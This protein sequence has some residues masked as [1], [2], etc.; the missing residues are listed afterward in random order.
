MSDDPILHAF[1]N[2]TEWDAWA[3]GWCRRCARYDDCQ[4]VDDLFM[5]SGAVPIQWIT[6]PLVL[7]PERYTCTEFAASYQPELPF[8]KEAE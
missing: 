4:I 1:S 7:G 3:S 8:P 6:G 2:G 5:G